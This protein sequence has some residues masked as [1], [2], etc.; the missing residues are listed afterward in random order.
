MALKIG[1]REFDSQ[2][3]FVRAGRRC[4]TPQLNDFQKER[5]RAHMRVARANG[6]DA[7]RLGTIT[8]PVH[9]HVIHDG[10]IGNIPDADLDEQLDVLNRD[11]NPHGINFTK[12]SV[13]R[14]DNT[15]FH[16]MTMGSP[17]ERNAKTALGRNQSNSLNLYTAGLGDSLLGWATFPSDLAGDP[18][19]DGVVVL[20]SSLPNGSSS[21]YNLGA[22]ATHEVGH[23]LG[24][25]HTFEGGCLAPGDE[26]SDTP[27]ESSPNFGPANPARDSCPTDPGKD[28]TTNFMDYTDDNGMT[29]FTAGQ[30]TRIKQ[31]VALYRPALLGGG[32]RVTDTAGIDL[33][34]GVF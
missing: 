20:F 22:T 28:P 23:W 17:A 4:G 1:A 32:A 10:G 16:H 18:V 14:T 6:M 3:T 29:E 27:F 21:P 24:L 19:R 8:I 7:D 15:V 9:F 34:T 2:E 12:A 31:Q 26:V 30:I 33:E 11:Y 13:D 25:Y 5:V